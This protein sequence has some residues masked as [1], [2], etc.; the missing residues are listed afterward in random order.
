MFNQTVENLKNNILDS[1]GLGAELY[2]KNEFATLTNFIDESEKLDSAIVC[3]IDEEINLVAF[4]DKRLFI[5]KKASLLG[6]MIKRIGLEGIRDLQLLVDE[7][8]GEILFSLF[9]NKEFKL[10]SISLSKAQKFG[11]HIVKRIQSWNDSF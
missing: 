10:T 11:K 7:G 5:I 9:D 6:S 1:E 2:L 3:L 8:N 4:S